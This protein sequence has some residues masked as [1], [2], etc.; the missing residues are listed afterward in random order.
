MK[1]A[2]FYITIFCFHIN[3]LYGQEFYFKHYKVED[4]LSHNTVL[5]SLQDQKGFLWFGTKNGLNRFDGYTFRLFQ[6][7]PIDPKGLKG[8]YIQSLHEFDHNVWVGTDN[9]LFKYN[10]KLQNFDFIE[11]TVN[12]PINDIEND[13]LGNLWY[14][15]GSTLIKY[16]PTTRESHNFPSE[17]FF[18]A[19]DIIKTQN[20]EIWVS[21]TNALF[22]YIKETDSFKKYVLDVQADIKHPFRIGKLLNLDNR[23]LLMGT[24]NHGLV[25]FDIIDEQIK[26][27]DFITNEKYYVRDLTM[28]G[29]DELWVAT[30]SGLHI[31]NLTTK[32]YTNLKKNYND[33]YALSDNAVYSLTV[34]NEGGVWAGTYF[35]G[36]N[37]QPKE[38][39]PFKKFFPMPSQNS[40]NGNAVREIRPD[41]YGNLWIGTEDAG[42]N[43]YDLK[44]GVFTN[45][46]S[47]DKDK[48]GILTYYNIHGLLP[49]GDELWIGMFEN[50]LDILNI[51]T[52]KIVKHYNIGEESALR[53]NFVFALF[54]TKAKDVFAIT[55]SGIQTYNQSNDQF[56]IYEPF[57]KNHHYTCFIEDYQG[58]LWAGTYSDGLYF[59]NPIT[60]EKGFFKYDETKET[61]IAHNH[62]NGIF[63]DSKNNLWITTENGLNFFDRKK[64]SF[65]KYTTK[66]GFPTNVFYAL[67]EDHLGNLWITTSNGLV[68]FDVQNDT[69]KIYTKANGLMSDQFNY[70]SAY[71]DSNGRMYFGSVN[72]MISFNPK[73]FVK[74]SFS[75]PIYITGLQIDNE[76]VFVGQ[77]D[78]PI[79]ESITLLDHLTLS[80]TQSSFSLDFAAL[81]YTAPHNT[82]YWYKMDGLYNDWIHLQKD[83]KVHFTELAPGTYYFRVKS[84]NSSGVWGQ[85]TS[86]LKIEVLPTFW[87]SNVAFAL[88]TFL[89]VLSVFLGFRFYHERIKA[90]NNQKIR[91]LNNRKEKEIYE[92]KIE[93]FTNVSHEIRTP[94][95]L[96]KSP[97]EKMI[98]SADHDTHLM[99]NLSIMEKNTS[100]LL[101]LAN[102]LLDFR[103][104]ELETINL[105]FVEV[106]ISNLI[107]KTHTRFSQAI[108]DKNID[109]DLSLGTKDIYAYVD[110]EAI[111]K[112]LSNLFNNAIK[113]AKKQVLVS[114]SL[115][116]G[117]IELTVK[118]D[119]QLIPVHLKDKIFE[120]FY[121]V[122]NT[123]NQ[124][125]SGT[126]IGLSLAHSLTD[127]HNGSLK[128]DT[129]DSTLNSFVLKL[130]IHQEKEFKL[131]VSKIDES[132]NGDGVSKNP[133]IG[134]YKPTVLLIE[135]N[136]DLLDFVAKDLVD[137]YLVIKATNAEKALETLAQENVQLI[138]SDVMMP[139]MD[140]FALCEK[141]KTDLESSHIPVILLTSKSALK[142]K[143][144][145]LE[146]GADAYIE[147][148]FSMEH[149]KVQIANLIENRKHIMQH[150][151]SSPLAH[152][153]SIAH[154]ETDE[155]FIRKLDEVIASHIS[156]PDLNVETLSDIMHMSRSTLYRKIKEMSD[157]SP[158]ELINVA[159][160][161]KAAELLRSGKH[162]IFEVA[163]IVGYNSPTS[164]GR[165]FQKQFEMTP[166]DYIKNYN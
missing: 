6:N 30:E 28:R 55:T 10:D 26:H 157:L 51:K 37:Y 103:K 106:N 132:T 86:A 135:D 9:G 134:S 39:T 133:E 50:G 93:F 62:V 128:L 5:S 63:Q 77:A 119:G 12:S 47:K 74:N 24:Q 111:K 38:Y 131:Y 145:G 16:N 147:K 113:Y 123:E 17:Q 76:D 97:L 18:N 95:T 107:R 108:K 114:L 14:I 54:E 20:N 92:A 118:N 49:R 71:K 115:D 163:E 85:E 166:S 105:T 140:G 138:V 72:G 41:N 43:K 124:N 129:T 144:E 65:R 25:A 146:S 101:D 13:T 88:Y 80:P 143:I 102:Q 153:R 84:K 126:G 7:D 152:I 36:I 116:D 81:G 64:K 141:I 109:F 159:R 112:I 142:A 78:S 150:F 137:H 4:G 98:K 23:T 99:E 96:I 91:Q 125:Q 110:T 164:F 151:T 22:H 89:I 60:R 156:D 44:T 154:T 19:T 21:S 70:N 8:N 73:N 90:K 122:P 29:K 1:K 155:T 57:P 104:T 130:P 58:V 161:K 2:I 100:R 34:D 27:I 117:N 158:N 11:D 40:I 121:R 162:R 68:E 136:V 94:L 35:G 148:P 56:D 59:Y 46:T 83:H 75:P 69:K 127:L 3:L 15:A 61:G 66:D 48:N 82:E 32:K 53:S 52:N 79:K 160:L 149:L 45:Y 67:L 42:L 120:P 87:K 139:G 165:N 31:Y 33:P